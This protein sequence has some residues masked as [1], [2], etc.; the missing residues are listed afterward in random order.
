MKWI[1]KR[2]YSSETRTLDFAAGVI[3]GGLATAIVIILF[4]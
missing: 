3:A 2:P 4:T 1:S